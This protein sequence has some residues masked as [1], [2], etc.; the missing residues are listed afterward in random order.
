MLPGTGIEGHHVG[1]FGTRRHCCEIANSSQVLQHPAARGMAEQHVI[2]QRDQAERPGRPATISAG[3]KL[4]TTGT[5]ACCA[6]KAI[7]PI[8]QVHATLRPR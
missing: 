1:H 8:C 2:E 7:S 4:E 6:S 3:R 5:P